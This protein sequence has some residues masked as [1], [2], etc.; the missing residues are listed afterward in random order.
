[1]MEQSRRVTRVVVDDVRQLRA[2]MESVTHELDLDHLEEATMLAEGLLELLV[3]EEVV[4]AL[5]AET[6]LRLIALIQ[7]VELGGALAAGSLGVERLNR[8][9]TLAR[10]LAEPRRIASFA[11]VKD[12]LPGQPEAPSADVPLPGPAST[13]WR[14]Y[15]VPRG[16]MWSL[17]ATLV[18]LLVI[19]GL[20]LW[21]TRSVEIRLM[22]VTRRFE[23]VT[24]EQDTTLTERDAARA[25]RDRTHAARE[26]AVAE[27]GRLRDAARTTREEIT[28]CTYE[29][30]LARTQAAMAAYQREAA[31]ADVRLSLAQLCTY[32]RGTHRGDEACRAYL[33]GRD[34]S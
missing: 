26:E 32:D 23:A 29:R 21:E 10:R 13:R 18:A 28:S 22:D 12:T 3:D 24:T 4:G 15:E 7:D 14:T 5:D 20:G 11:S 2:L 27:N 30:D 9:R 34:G 19:V 16:A 25:D 8:I 31:R 33:A 6:R 17:L 1:M